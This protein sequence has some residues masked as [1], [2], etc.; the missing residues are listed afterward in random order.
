MIED[1]E[2][3]ISY[4]FSKKELLRE[5]LTHPSYAHE[6]GSVRH[7]ER[8]EFLGDAVIGLVITDYLLRKYPDK[9]EGELARIKGHLVS[10]GTLAYLARKIGLGPFIFLGSGDEKHGLRE[11]ESTLANAFEALIGAI[12]L[13]GGFEKAKGFLLNQFESILSEMEKCVFRRKDPKTE[14]QEILQKRH[15]ALP[16]YEI[17]SVN[18]PEHEPIFKVRIVFKGKVLGMGTGR[19]KKEAEK[20]AAKEA[21]STL[22]R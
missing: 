1:L 11:R 19:N 20:N 7:S 4:S 3:K 14:L 16:K 22:D 5:A 2:Q 10:K 21:L 12:Y 15:K 13:D 6:K 9:R 8:L 17:V 18:G